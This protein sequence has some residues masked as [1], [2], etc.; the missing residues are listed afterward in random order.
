MRCRSPIRSEALHV[1]CSIAGPSVG[2]VLR[3]VCV[4]HVYLW[5]PFY[6]SRSIDIYRMRHL[7]E[8]VANALRKLSFANC[9]VSWRTRSFCK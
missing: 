3:G 8:R 5:A 4:F 2:G 7:H 6:A 9:E 1:G